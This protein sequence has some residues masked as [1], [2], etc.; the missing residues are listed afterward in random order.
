MALVGSM[1]PHVFRN[2]LNGVYDGAFEC[3]FGLEPGTIAA[4]QESGEIIKG[5]GEVID[6][7]YIA[8]LTRGQECDPQDDL[9]REDGS[10]QGV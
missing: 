9:H 2:A 8:V 7:G 1:L 4:S 6:K 5:P 10:L 3:R